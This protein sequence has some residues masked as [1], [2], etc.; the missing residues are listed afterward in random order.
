MLSINQDLCTKINKILPQIAFEFETLQMIN[1][2]PQIIVIIKVKYGHGGEI[3]LRYGC[4]QRNQYQYLLKESIW[5]S[6][7]QVY[8]WPHQ[9]LNHLMIWIRTFLKD[10]DMAFH[11][12]QGKLILEKN[13]IPLLILFTGVWQGE[14]TPHPIPDHMLTELTIVRLDGNWWLSLPR[15]TIKL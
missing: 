4:S 13:N 3:D 15:N 8:Y 5:K 7:F 6:A 1:S 11:S 9:V 14:E 2:P 12:V 10:P